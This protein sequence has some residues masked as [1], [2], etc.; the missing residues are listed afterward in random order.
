MVAVVLL[1][2]CAFQLALALGA[3]LGGAA[4][5]GTHP[6]LPTG[7]RWASL[8]P[9]V[10]YVLGG[11]VVLR[12]AGFRVP[13]IPMTLA[14]RGTWAFAI[15]LGLSAVA[16]LASHSGW[17]RYLMAPVALFLAVL[18]VVVARSPIPVD[19]AAPAP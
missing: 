1:V 4:W 9:I 6:T 19:Q 14:R 3:P 10:L 15:I 11:W 5:G 8:I 18:C 2:L 13:G 12:R 17:E 16:N 7:L